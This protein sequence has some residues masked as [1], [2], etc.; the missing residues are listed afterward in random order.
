MRDGSQWTIR[1]PVYSLVSSQRRINLSSITL[2]YQ[3]YLFTLLSQNITFSGAFAAPNTDNLWMRIVVY[4]KTKADYPT[5]LNHP[6]DSTKLVAERIEVVVNLH[7]T[8]PSNIVL[9][10]NA[11]SQISVVL[12]S[13]DWTNS[14][15]TWGTLFQRNFDVG[16]KVNFDQHLIPESQ[17]SQSSHE[18]ASLTKSGFMSSQDKQIFTNNIGGGGDK[19]ALVNPTDAG[20]SSTKD[21]IY[22]KNLQRSMG[23]Y[24]LWLSDF[25]G[26]FNDMKN[27]QGTP[28]NQ[29][30]PSLYYGSH[31]AL[32]GALALHKYNAPHNNLDSRVYYLFFLVH[33]I[34]GS[35]LS[36]FKI[37]VYANG[38]AN[39]LFYHSQHSS[40]IEGSEFPNNNTP[41]NP[42]SAGWQ[43]AGV[44]VSGR[45]YLGN[46]D[47]SS[48]SWFTLPMQ[49]ETTYSLCFMVCDDQYDD[50]D[51][52][53]TGSWMNTPPISGDFDARIVQDPA[54]IN[55]IASGGQF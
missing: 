22:V 34:G 18:N 29:W 49:S 16:D 1:N 46:N 47:G 25:I 14:K 31:V 13:I 19:H 11:I 30:H 40:K 21:F 39:R 32:N 38:D 23:V 2:S 12:G 54:Y 20:F 5:L 53:Q 4:Q 55:Y 26:N 50:I 45:N 41:L 8:D 37:P 51:Y 44:N 33:A 36:T 17:K 24:N 15:I 43:R 52:L 28:S 6:D 9:P 3:G 42:A 27:F 48:N 10:V 7:N 35:G